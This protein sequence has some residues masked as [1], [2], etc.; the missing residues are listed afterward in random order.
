MSDIQNNRLVVEDSADN[1]DNS[2]VWIASSTMEAMGIFRGDNVLLKGNN[3]HESVASVLPAE[4]LEG[5]IRMSK[6]L[7]TNLRVCQGDVVTVHLCQRDIKFGARVHIE[8]I[9]G[10]VEGLTED[11]CKVYLRD[12]LGLSYRPV[13]RGDLIVCNGNRG[14]VEFKVLACDP[15]PYCV[16]APNTAICTKSVWYENILDE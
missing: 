1:G 16:V 3:N 9:E 10:N 12:Y 6:I 7:R 8:P 13:H 14:A 11:V 5:R 4:V 2:I 15:D